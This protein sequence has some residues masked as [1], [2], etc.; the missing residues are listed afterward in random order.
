MQKLDGKTLSERAIESLK[1]HIQTHKIQAHLTAIL[2]GDNPA[3][4]TYLRAKSH[5]CTRAG[6]SFSDTL[7]PE[8]TSQTELEEYIESL[9]T[10]PQVHAM[11]VQLPLP[12]HIDTEAIIECIAPHKDVDGFHPFNLGSIMRETKGIVPCTPK[13]IIDLCD[14]YKISLQ[15]KHVVIVNRSLIVG[16]P[17]ALLCCNRTHNATVTIC[18]SK[19]DDLFSYTR[20]ADILVSGIGRKSFFRAEH[21]KTGATLI[22]V[23]INIVGKSPSGKFII[24]GDFDEASVS[25][26]ARYYTP[27]PGGVGPMTVTALLEN[28]IKCYE[29][30]HTT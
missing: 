14:A 13:G 3:S 17:L 30:S 28:T 16:K 5:A 23:S 11:L 12:P 6:I 25:A 7:L 15:N 8:T 9:N 19:T 20:S 29:Y 26:K 22:D 1:D 10:D 2:V 24:R 21:I 18:H 4:K 27:V